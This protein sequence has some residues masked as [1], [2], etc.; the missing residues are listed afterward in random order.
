MDTIREATGAHVLF[1]HH[2]GKDAS[3]G[4][5][6]HS[7][8]RAAVD[9]EIEVTANDEAGTREAR[10]VK[11]REMPKGLKFPFSLKVVEMGKN[12]YD[13]P[14]TSCVVE[15]AEAGDVRSR[16][17]MSGDVR[18]AFDIL[19][20]AIA[21]HGATGFDGVPGDVPSIKEEWW[22]D[23]FFDRA[24]AGASPDAKRMAFRRAADEL[25]QRRAVGM[26][27]GRV[28]VI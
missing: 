3:R 9:T 20:D 15:S 12:R 21:T 28:W 5:R 13:E 14:V 6:G 19:N 8:L 24:K 23:R 26:D 1:I 4:A 2:S 18:H 10:V 16:K 17:R 27:K 11:Q 7:L 25:V 22:R